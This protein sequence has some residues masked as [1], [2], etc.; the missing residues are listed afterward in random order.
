MTIGKITS[1]QQDIAFVKVRVEDDT[2]T[3]THNGV[4]KV[5][6]YVVSSA[7]Q[8]FSVA[9]WFSRIK[10]KIGNVSAPGIVKVSLY[11]SPQ[12]A[13][14]YAEAEAQL[15]AGGQVIHFILL[16]PYPP[17]DYYWEMAKLSGGVGISVVTD[18][19]IHKAYKEGS[20]T[21]EWDIESK[22]MHLGEETEQPIAVEGDEIDGGATT[23]LSG[24]AVSFI[25]QE[26][27]ARVT[28]PLANGGKI[29]QG[30]KFLEA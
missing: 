13:A 2:F 8:Q 17:G 6:Y 24:S 7:G 18:S 21:A 19:T 3:D 1:S 14:K 26:A 20:P 4:T 28:D 15:N 27:I 10:I 25:A 23:I 16:D 5:N 22:I 29:L 9:K 11:D 30:C 12:K